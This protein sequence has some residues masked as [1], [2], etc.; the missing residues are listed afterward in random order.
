MRARRGTA[1]TAVV[2]GLALVDD[3]VAALLDLA[4]TARLV[5]VVADRVEIDDTVTARG[6]HARAALTHTR[7]FRG[8][9]VALG[10]LDAGCELFASGAEH[11]GDARRR[12]RA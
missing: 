7:A 4:V 9:R 12:A 1:I 3:R 6:R 5:A 8:A 10:E 11:V 2:A